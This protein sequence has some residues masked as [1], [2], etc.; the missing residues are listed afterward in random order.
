[1][2]LNKKGTIGFNS[3]T[4]VVGLVLLLLLAFIAYKAI[5]STD[6]TGTRISEVAECE[7]GIEGMYG[8]CSTI[9]CE[10]TGGDAMISKLKSCPSTRLRLGLQLQGFSKQ[11]RE[12]YKYCC[13][14]ESCSD[15]TDRGEPRIPG[16][17]YGD[18]DVEI[19]KRDY[20]L[21][22]KG[23]NTGYTEDLCLGYAKDCL[24]EDGC[25][26]VIDQSNR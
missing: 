25:C 16:C 3:I 18:E 6:E 14:V 26:C 10:A 24:P 1:M 11:E 4:L 15:I 12:R 20:S 8:I 21:C 23:H 2:K 19:T 9:P 22:K 13:V 7:R 17:F 5:V